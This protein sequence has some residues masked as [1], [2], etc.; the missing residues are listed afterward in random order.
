MYE[1]TYSAK[2]LKQNT[3][4]EKKHRKKF[5]WKKFFMAALV[6]ILVAVVVILVRTPKL[7]VH[8]VEVEGTHVTD[9]EE[10]SLFVKSQIEGNYLYFFP[11][12]SMLLVPTTTIKK[13]LAS[14]FPRFST[15][16]VRRKGIN[17]LLV[18]VS[19]YQGEFLWCESDEAC[20]FMTKDGIVFAEAPFFSGNAYK[21][22]FIGKKETLPFKP[23]EENYMSVVKLLIE[24]LPLILIEPTE[25]R[26]SSEHQIDITFYHNG[27][28][29]LLMV[30]PSGGI[31]KMLE[32]L[33]TGLNTEPL[34]SEFKNEKNILQSL[35]A[36]FANKIVYKFK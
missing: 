14:A 8:D 15:L 33:A 18:N 30:D 27:N 13:R 6:V 34:K 2:V 32:D 29:A 16:D 7:Q 26:Q 9:P 5:A 22:I 17:N 31:E 4:P 36:R 10:V 35:D 11:K 28:Q 12:S 3:P 25:F 20:F 24:R 19:E 21:K 23:V 1:R